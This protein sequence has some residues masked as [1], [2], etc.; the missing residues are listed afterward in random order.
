MFGVVPRICFA[1]RFY[2]LGFL[3]MMEYPPVSG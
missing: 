2:L 3:G 1:P